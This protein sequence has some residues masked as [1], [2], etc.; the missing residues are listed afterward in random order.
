V[1][2]NGD[3][4]FGAFVGQSGLVW[5]AARPASLYYPGKH[6]LSIANNEKFAL[7]FH[8]SARQFFYF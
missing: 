5:P 3:R 6:S 7:N 4:A 1:G 2:E 8:L